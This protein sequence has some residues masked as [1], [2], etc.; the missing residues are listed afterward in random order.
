MTR[1]DISKSVGDISDRYLTEAM[2]GM[3]LDMADRPV[4]ET[5]MKKRKVLSFRKI[6]SIAAAACLVMA[7]GIIA[8]SGNLFGI[9]DMLSRK[10]ID[11]SE[12]AGEDIVIYDDDDYACTSPNGWGA[13]LTESLYESG[14]AIITL[15]AECD[16]RYVLAP[17]DA[18][19]EDAYDDH[20]TLAE[21]ADDNDKTIL[22]VG[23]ALMDDKLNSITASQDFERISD[24]EME[25]LVHA[26]IANTADQIETLCSVYAREDGHSKVEDV[27]RMEIPFT[28]V[29][30]KSSETAWYMPEN[31]D[32]TDS[33]HIGDA[34]MIS[35]LLG[36][37]IMI[38]LDGKDV[39]KIGKISYAGSGSTDTTVGM[40]LGR[41]DVWRIHSLLENEK[42]DN[43]F[44]LHFYDKDDSLIGDVVFKK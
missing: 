35:T 18:A 22:Y 9:R 29:Q 42:V 21:Y 32:L 33:I 17:T 37:E 12:S 44:T 28:L 8:Y 5:I 36:T 11:F 39:E 20:T 26:S 19:P 34:Q 31:A 13:R 23:A 4:E 27:Q 16:D 40:V 3:N 1:R 41:D 14:N 43:S 2:N 24:H 10:G 6:I 15:R 25:V 30:G 38:E 7:S